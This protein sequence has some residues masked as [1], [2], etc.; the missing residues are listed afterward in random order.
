MERRQDGASIKDEVFNTGKQR[1]VEKG[2]GGT[3]G[4]RIPRANRGPGKPSLPHT[5]PAPGESILPHTREME[6]ERKQ[7]LCNTAHPW[8]PPRV[9]RAGA[10][11]AAIPL[12][13]DPPRPPSVPAWSP[14]A[15][16]AKHP[17]EGGKTIKTQRERGPNLAELG[18]RHPY[19]HTHSP[20]GTFP[21]APPGRPRPRWPRAGLPRR[22]RAEGR[23]RLLPRPRGRRARRAVPPGRDSCAYLVRHGSAPCRAA[24][25]A[26]PLQALRSFLCPQRKHRA[27]ARAG[28]PVRLSSLPAR[29]P[30]A[31]APGLRTALPRRPRPTGPTGHG[32]GRWER[33]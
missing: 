17:G 8:L 3:P 20:R 26:G 24:G 11:P 9:P 18:D 14:P 13:P 1:S 23:R 16:P 4:F 22:V 2:G 21:P 31:A 19:I 25:S 32:N 30:P 10:V 6:N 7:Q 29:A 33:R 15:L 27:A 28:F 12:R 5:K